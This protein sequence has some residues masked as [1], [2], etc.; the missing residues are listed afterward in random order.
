MAFHFLHLETKEV[1][2]GTDDNVD[3]SR[4]ANLCPQ[5]VL[6]IC[7]NIEIILTI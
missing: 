3:S 4:A 6:K 5:V 7:S 1:I 2:D